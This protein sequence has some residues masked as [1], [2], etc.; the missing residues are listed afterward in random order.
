MSY[1]QQSEK[2]VVVEDGPHTEAGSITAEVLLDK[3]GF[4]LFPIPVQGDAL[5]PLN[6]SWIQ[7]HVILSIVMALCENVLKTCVVG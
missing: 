6:W 3:N 1:E 7:K 5:D 2:K 4:R